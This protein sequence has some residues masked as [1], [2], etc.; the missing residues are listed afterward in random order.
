M[1]SPAQAVL[2]QIYWRA[3]WGFAAA[4]LFLL[5]AI[6]LTHLLP[7]HWTIHVDPMENVPV[8]G[9]FFGITC[10]WAN[11]IVM[12]AFGMS[13][14]ESR[15][16]TFTKHMFVL[17]VRTS[18]LVAWPMFS[19]CLTVAVI[20]L[21]NALLVFRASGIAAPLWYPAAA[22]ALLLATFQALAWTPF[23]QRWL[24]IGLT[25]A[26]LITPILVILVVLIL[27]IQVSEWAV[28]GIL[29]GLIPIAYVAAV[30]G[31]AK[32]RRGDAFDWRAWGRFVE[33][34]GTL[35]PAVTHPF[36]SMSGAQVWYECRAHMLV[37]VFI[38]CML[39]CFIFVP[40]MERDNVALGWRLL[41]TMLMM[42]L[43]MALI[44]G[45]SLGNL[46]DP[47]SK[48]EAGSFVLVRPIS[49]LAIVRG[50]LVAAVV[51]TAAIWIPFFG[52][53]ALLLTRPGFPQSIAEVA[54]RVPMWKAIGY[55]AILLAL[56]VLFTWKTMVE[57]LW[58][59]LTGRKWVENAITFTFIG[60][61][62]VGMGSGL[63]VGF[64]P[65]L[66]QPAL[67]VVPWL[68]GLMLIMKLAAG[69]FVVRGLILSRLITAGGAAMMIAM[70]LAV[71][72]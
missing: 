30:S 40:A 21:I 54:S 72:G 19:G 22:F 26:V 41:G 58:V 29:L 39:P 55:S 5:L 37:P 46:T 31:L 69:G 8:V 43:L 66:H 44:A 38:A 57:S 52:Y 7:R 59:C 13:S 1:N 64:H 62:F 20:W 27:N 32:A 17:P 14:A 28:T 61:L 12:T 11:F 35:R 71:V 25:V 70:W 56:L 47:F 16:L 18:T 6:T 48:F 45:G 60:L 34:L 50:K 4:A 2:W 23:A 10:L 3:R 65:E 9:W 63:W 15:N 53:L 24:H 42:P 51:T 49:S 67:A 68:I 36:R 33:W